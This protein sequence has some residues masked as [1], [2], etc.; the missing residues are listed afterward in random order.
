MVYGTEAY[1]GEKV[2]YPHSCIYPGRFWHLVP[3]YMKFY[4]AMLASAMLML[5]QNDAQTAQSADP[6]VPSQSAD[7][8]ALVLG[9]GG[10][11][12]SRMLQFLVNDRNIIV[13]AV[14][15]D[16][17]VAKVAHD[18]FDFDAPQVT[19]AATGKDRTTV[20]VDDALN[21]VQQRAT[22]PTKL[23]QE[24]HDTVST[25]PKYDIVIQDICGKVKTPKAF[26]TRSWFSQVKALLKDGN[27][28]FVVNALDKNYLWRRR[29]GDAFGSTKIARISDHSLVWDNPIYSISPKKDQ[30]K[31]STVWGASRPWSQAGID[32]AEMENA[33]E[34]IDV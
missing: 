6:T 1:G 8:H 11:S 7:L 20:F 14:E 12:L 30:P 31:E 2:I 34:V 13:H 19:G 28:R 29:L 10:G 16:P 17:A 23:G 22:I 21:F 9:S 33:I 27:S 3:D 4:S 26:L 25:W 32:L 15:L 5:D 24:D 18:Y